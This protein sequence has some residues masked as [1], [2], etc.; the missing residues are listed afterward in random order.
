LAAS[1]APADG[2]RDGSIGGRERLA[3][4]LGEFG[5][6][7]GLVEHDGAGGGDD[8]SKKVISL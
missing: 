6:A 2:A 7:V 8:D 3:P 1:D 5:L 4:A